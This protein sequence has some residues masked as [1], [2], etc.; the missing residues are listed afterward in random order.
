LCKAYGLSDQGLRKVCVKLQIPLPT[1]GH[2]AKIAAG[3][4]LVK[5]ALP[6]LRKQVE[7]RKPR[8]KPEA[9]LLDAATANRAMFNLG[10]PAPP[11]VK[12]LD[13]VLAELARDYELADSQARQLHA[14]YVWEAEHPGKR[15]TG[16]APSY[17]SWEY[18]CDAGRILCPT[19]KKSL[20]RVSM[21]SYRRAL[22]ILHE[23]V[24]RLHQ[25]GFAVD[26]PKTRER[27]HAK[28]GDAVIEIKLV[29]KLEVGQRKEIRSWTKEPRLVRTLN[30]TGRLTLGVEQMGLGE[31]LISDRKDAPIE[32]Q[33]EQVMAAVEHRHARSLER[34]AEWDR[35]K[36]EYADRERERQERLRLQEEAR[37]AE[38]RESARRQ[39]LLQEARNWKDANLLREYLQHLEARRAA[40]GI[41]VEGYEAWAAWADEVAAA[42]DLSAQ[43][44][45]PTTA[46]NTHRSTT[47]VGPAR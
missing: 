11:L 31:T 32:K 4:V 9:P 30:P 16:K 42:L 8:L 36:R 3:H 39:A 29:E 28:R 14:K 33:W 12:G 38:E 43:R 40:G 19:H 41:A 22:N 13:P 26:V 7:D 46:S 25:A 35:S 20:L 27:L 6:P 15:Y 24:N 37:Q 44:V 10:E 23:L 21:G 18:F 17:G 1:R 2:W 5:P 47:G 34:I 45:G